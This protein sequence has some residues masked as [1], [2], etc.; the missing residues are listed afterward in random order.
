MDIQPKTYHVGTLTYTTSTLRRLFFWL[1]WGDFCFFMVETVVPSIIPLMFKELKASN[2]LIGIVLATIPRIISSVLNPV[3]SFKSD[4]LRSRWGRRIPFLVVTMP[5][6][7]LC[8]V[9]LAFAIDIS[10]W[11][12][13]TFP[14][15]GKSISPVNSRQTGTL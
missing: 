4:R 13:A 6:L 1:L 2:L 10:E 5:F 15:L 3:I 9:G 8:F 7:V 11:I 14:A 12:S